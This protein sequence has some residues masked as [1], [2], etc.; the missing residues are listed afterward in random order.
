[1][2]DVRRKKCN[3]ASGAEPCQRNTSLISLISSLS[4]WSARASIS[5]INPSLLYI[6]DR[7]ILQ[8][9]LGHQLHKHIS[10]ALPHKLLSK[11]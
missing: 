5:L 11:N 6:R 10:Q 1:M 9:D 7:K 4:L 8:R 3:D 2:G